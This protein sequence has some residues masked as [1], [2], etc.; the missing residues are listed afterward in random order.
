MVRK[1]R[2]EERRVLLEE[3][4]RE[5]EADRARRSEAD[6]RRAEAIAARFETDT[7]EIRWRRRRDRVGLLG[8]LQAR[9]LGLVRGE[10][11]EE[12][13]MMTLGDLAAAGRGEAG[14]KAEAEANADADADADGGAAAGGLIVPRLTASASA[15]SASEDEEDDDD[16]A[17]DASPEEEEKKN[18]KKKKPIV[19]RRGVIDDSDSSDDEDGNEDALAGSDPD[20]D[21][22]G[23]DSD[24]D[25]EIVAGPPARAGAPAPPAAERPP[26]VSDARSALDILEGAA[27]P[28]QVPPRGGRGGPPAGGGAGGG[29]RSALR[30][31]LRTKQVRAGNQWLARELGYRDEAEHIRDCLNVEERKRRMTL[32][33]EE[34][35]S[36]RTRRQVELVAEGNLDDIDELLGDGGQ[37]AA[38][39]ALDELT[40]KDAAGLIGIQAEEEEDEELVLARKIEKEREEAEDEAEDEAASANVKSDADSVDGGDAPT[41]AA[42][43]NNDENS[44]TA[45]DGNPDS[46]TGVDPTARSDP[47]VEGVVVPLPLSKD[48]GSSLEQTDTTSEVDAASTVTPEK[49]EESTNAE[50]ENDDDGETEFDD[51]VG[52]TADKPKKAK[53]AAWQAM[54]KKEAEMLKRQKKR[55]NGLVEA[56]ADEEEDEEGVAG[57]EDF[58]FAV[59][60]K[61][62]GD[63]EEEEPDGIDEDDLENVVDDLSDNEGDEEAGE[64]ARRDMAAREE[65]ERHKDMM[66]RMREGYDGRR[67][68]VAGGGS[69]RGN[70]RFD[71]LVAADNRDDARRL[72]LLNDD[73][74][75]SDN[76][77]GKEK[78][79]GDDE[80]EDETALLDQ[81]LKDRFL[82]RDREAELEENFSDDED[83]EDDAEGEDEGE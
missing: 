21:G 36:E 8:R 35:R 39:G 73:E 34:A 82:Q 31:A 72:G 53:N 49:T 62:K 81:M 32:R 75:D 50:T 33:L 28:R 66:R 13:E 48:E 22:S 74:L 80:I 79:E 23:S 43:A 18:E 64:H 61:K 29:A 4:G 52:D 6:R 60:D 71:Q 59:N 40:N 2:A 1:R 51:S 47:M 76:E 27:L 55:G 17:G 70:L 30:S 9:R 38:S 56:E 26:C 63:E 14:G 12:E 83:G 15:A 54:L 19:A 5:A 20:D 41:A 45:D 10:E 77:G 78:K 3:V 67:G 16:G 58:G 65:K 46:K 44:P 7:D 11:E 69:A 68:G 37:A 24:G 42:D 25:L 57:L